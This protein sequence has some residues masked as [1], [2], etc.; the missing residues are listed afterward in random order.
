MKNFWS[1][2]SFKVTKIFRDPF[3]WINRFLWV[4]LPPLTCVNISSKAYFLLILI[5]VSYSHIFYTHSCE[6]KSLRARFVINLRLKGT[7]EE[8]FFE[9][10]FLLFLINHTNHNSAIIPLKRRKWRS[11]KLGIDWKLLDSRWVCL[12]SFSF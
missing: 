6:N 9:Q 3:K 8:Q 10:V 11:E 4:D 5:I 12:E 7:V 2:N 1:N